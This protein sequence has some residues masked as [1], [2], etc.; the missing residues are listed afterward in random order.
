MKTKHHRACVE[1]VNASFRTMHCSSQLFHLKCNC[2]CHI[3][4]K[5]SELSSGALVM[6]YHKLKILRYSILFYLNYWNYLFSF[7]APS[8][9]GRGSCIFGAGRLRQLIDHLLRKDLFSAYLIPYSY[10]KNASTSVSCSHHIAM[11]D[12]LYPETDFNQLLF[13]FC[14]FCVLLPALV[15][16]SHK[17]WKEDS[18]KFNCLQDPTCFSFCIKTLLALSGLSLCIV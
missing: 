9:W 10:T 14:L 17:R 8:E 1:W 18:Q 11:Q 2:N 3:N 13:F 4:M 7:L 15:E 5:S 16:A 12:I 6:A